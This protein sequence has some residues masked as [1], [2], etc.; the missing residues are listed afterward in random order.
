M[1]MQLLTSVLLLAT[2]SVHGYGH[3]AFDPTSGDPFNVATPFNSVY[4][5]WY[6]TT[7]ESLP[8][9]AFNVSGIVRIRQMGDKVVP[10]HVFPEYTSQLLDYQLVGADPRCFAMV[11]GP[12]PESPRST[13][14][15]ERVRWKCSWKSQTVQGP[16]GGVP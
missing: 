2:S 4:G 5:A 15:L 9:S 7:F 3:E 1:G 11:Q 6:A 12:P 8:G 13:P 16:R 14:P 10:P